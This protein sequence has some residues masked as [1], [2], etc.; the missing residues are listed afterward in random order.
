VRR[1]NANVEGR[2]APVGSGNSVPLASAKMTLAF[3]LASAKVT[4]VWPVELHADVTPR[5][6]DTAGGDVTWLA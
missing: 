5:A 4:G 3:L 6:A 1:G 2:A